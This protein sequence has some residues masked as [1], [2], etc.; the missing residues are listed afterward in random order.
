MVLYIAT[1]LTSDI[2]SLYR[3]W[4]SPIHWSCPFKHVAQELAW[5]NTMDFIFPAST[6]IV[7]VMIHE[8]INVIRCLT[9]DVEPTSTD[10]DHA[11]S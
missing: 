2:T 8:E 5:M 6:G 4:V 1:I 3:T 7:C 9:I 11:S 10:E